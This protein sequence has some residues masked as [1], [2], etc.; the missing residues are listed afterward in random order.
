MPITAYIALGSNLGDRRSFLDRALLLLRA[1]SGFRVHRISSYHETAPVG[2]RP[3]QEAYLNAVA[4][5]ETDLSPD[6]LLHRLLS[7][8]QLLGR[9]RGERNA[10]RTIDLDIVLYGDLVRTS[11][12]P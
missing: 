5:I 7:I 3:G 1:Q 11:P 12:D 6:E 9:S 4:E 2:G 8:E 10:P